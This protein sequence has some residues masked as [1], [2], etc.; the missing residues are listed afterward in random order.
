MVAANSV[1]VSRAPT[2][3]GTPLRV[4]SVF[5]YGAITLYRRPFHAVPLT[6]GLV[7][8]CQGAALTCRSHDPPYAT[9]AAYT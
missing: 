4:R 1:K 6:V 8:L 5:A 7:T 9:P 2:Y 3:L